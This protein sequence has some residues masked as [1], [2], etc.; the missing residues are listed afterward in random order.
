MTREN[1]NEAESQV[2]PFACADVRVWYRVTIVVRTL[3]K[4][5]CHRRLDVVGR[6][7]P[8]AVSANRTRADPGPAPRTASAAPHP[9]RRQHRLRHPVRLLQIGRAHV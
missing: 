6:P 2:R 4:K 9:Q 8:V 7:G 3:A 5:V 1:V